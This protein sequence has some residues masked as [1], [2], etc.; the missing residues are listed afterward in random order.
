MLSAPVHPVCVQ[1]IPS[2][3]LH[4]VIGDM[5]DVDVITILYYFLLM[6]TRG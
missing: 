1:I 2:L 6:S 4:A 3:L 5:S